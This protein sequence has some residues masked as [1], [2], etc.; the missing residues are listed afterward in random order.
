VTAKLD[1]SG[2][3]AAVVINLFN[4]QGFEDVL[5]A[6]MVLR[7]GGWLIGYC[8][9]KRQGQDDKEFR[10]LAGYREDESQV[11]R[12]M[13]LGGV[14]S[15]FFAIC[16]SPKATSPLPTNFWPTKIWSF[17]TRILADARLLR[18]SMAPYVSTTFSSFPFLLIAM[19]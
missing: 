5:W 8:V 14:I 6:K 9:T 11:E 18:Q 19:L 13:R 17:I 7:S 4:L 15:L 12:Q 1:T 10:K 3:L 16:T 2:P